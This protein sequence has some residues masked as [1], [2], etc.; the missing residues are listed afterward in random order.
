MQRRFASALALALAI[1][2]PSSSLAAEIK[3]GDTLAC[4]SKDPAKRLFAVIGR[5]E[6]FGKGTAASITLYNLTP[7]ARLPEVSHLPFD[8]ATLSASCTPSSDVTL[9]TSATFDDGYATW[10]KAVEDQKAGV[11]TVPVDQ[12]EDILLG[13][14]QGQPQAG[15][16]S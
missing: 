6:P 12:I 15:T 2:A 11:F 3:V 4:R 7:G 13:T 1:V 5:L 10:R 9:P 16:R 8:L 14:L